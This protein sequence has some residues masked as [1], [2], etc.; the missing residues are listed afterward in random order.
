MKDQHTKIKGYRDLS[1]KEIDLMNKIKAHAEETQELLN[2]VGALRESQQRFAPT[3]GLTEEQIQES[4]RCLALA[5]TN[6][7]QG[8]MWFVRAVALPDS[9]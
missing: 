7:Q 2:Q 6:L 1:Q 8:T 4:R 9:F 3:D 5:K